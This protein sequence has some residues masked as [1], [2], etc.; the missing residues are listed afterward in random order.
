MRKLG[1][2][3]RTCQLVELGSEEGSLPLILGQGLVT[4]K[5]AVFVDPDPEHAPQ[6]P[7]QLPPTASCQQRP[8]TLALSRL[9]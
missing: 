1:L 7:E 5:A 9:D 8:L 6:Q 4:R 2:V 3:G